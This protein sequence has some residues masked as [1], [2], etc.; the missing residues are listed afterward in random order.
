MT[1]QNADPF[2]ILTLPEIENPKQRHVPIDSLELPTG[3]L[4]GVGEVSKITGDSGLTLR[5][6]HL[7]ILAC[8]ML[9]KLKALN[10]RARSQ[11]AA[12]DK[13]FLFV[14][15]LS[16]SDARSVGCK[17]V[18]RLYDERGIS[19]WFD[20]R[21]AHEETGVWFWLDDHG[22][23]CPVRV[24]DQERIAD[25]DSPHNVVNVFATSPLLCGDQ[26]VGTVRWTDH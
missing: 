25:E 15:T 7:W 5:I 26:V 9:K 22:Y 23:L 11:L 6:C 20:M 24:G 14:E 16:G 13:R 2:N 19:E 21:D 18:L 17:H 10:D 8:D 3:V 1:F 12:V 4:D